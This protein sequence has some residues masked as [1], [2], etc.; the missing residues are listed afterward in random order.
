MHLNMLRKRKFMS[1]HNQ[2]Q[3]NDSERLLPGSMI[4]QMDSFQLAIILN[5]G[6]HEGTPGGI[7]LRAVLT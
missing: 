2:P 6:E 4:H 1:N 7:D 5:A 3:P